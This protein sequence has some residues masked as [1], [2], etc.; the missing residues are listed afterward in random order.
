[1]KTM[2]KVTFLFAL[3]AFANTLFAA[4]NL[5]VNIVPVKAEKAVIAISKLSDSNFD[6]TIADENGQ[7]VYYKE[8]SNPS[9]NYRKVYDF[10]DLEDGTYYLTVASN[11]L[12]TE[13]QFS[14]SHGQITVGEEKTTLQPFF[15]YQA[16][17][18]KCSYLNFEKDKVTLIFYKNDEQIYSKKIGR[19]FNIHHALNL[20]KLDKG[21]YKAVLYAGEK[22]FKYPIEIQ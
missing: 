7:I 2:L 19:D 6:I 8:N 1:M 14:L 18:L 4:G 20:S 10:S 21:E 13:R 5:K 3:V 12:T 22:Q 15:G 11:D 16:G 17:I 9:E